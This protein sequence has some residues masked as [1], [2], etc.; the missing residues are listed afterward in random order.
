M[1]LESKK[2]PQHNRSSIVIIFSVVAQSLLGA[3][4]LDGNRHSRYEV[5]GV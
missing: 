1:F 5:S 3:T 2:Y 4:F